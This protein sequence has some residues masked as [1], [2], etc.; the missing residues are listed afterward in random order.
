VRWSGACTAA[1]ARTISA[2]V[3]ALS[4]VWTLKPPFLVA[5]WARLS[6]AAMSQFAVLYDDRFTGRLD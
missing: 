2:L 4:G 1:A 6:N 5:V 3:I